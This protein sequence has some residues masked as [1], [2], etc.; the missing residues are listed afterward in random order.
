MKILDYFKSNSLFI[1]LNLI[2]FIVVSICVIFISKGFV[3][4]GILFLVWFTPLVIYMIVDAVRYRKYFKEINDILDSL[5]KKYLLPEVIKDRD[6]IV[7][8]RINEVF[9]NLGRDMHEHI[10][11]YKDMQES[12]REYIDTWVHEI[13]T[14]IA[15]SKLIVDNNNNEVT[16]KIDHQLNKIDNYVEQVLYYSRSSEAYKDYIIKEVDILKSVQNVVRRN[17]RDFIS[18]KISIDILDIDRNVYS[19][20]K[21][22]EF[23]LNQIIGN[24]IKYINKEGS[25]IRI[26]LKENESQIILIIEDNGIGIP[27]RD[28]RRVFEKGFTGDNGRK[29][30]K[31]TGMGLYL[32]YK[33]CKKLGLGIDL[34]SEEG[35]GTKVYLVFP[36]S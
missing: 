28:V 16:R 12:Y 32:C 26:Y 36:V 11:L 24:S 5:D 13:K 18:K 27:Q 35:V 10:K 19:D 17:Y 8:D 31:S 23:I 34:E 1:A 2:A 21:W 29:F 33:L 14:P 30:T 15:S 6:F 7:M 25:K 9:K 3:I 4:I 22:V 20:T